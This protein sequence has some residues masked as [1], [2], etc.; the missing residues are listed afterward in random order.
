MFIFQQF[1]SQWVSTIGD[2][3]AC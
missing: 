2:M 1:G 3:L